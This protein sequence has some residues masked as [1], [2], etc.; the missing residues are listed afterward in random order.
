MMN[1]EEKILN[2]IIN[3]ARRYKEVQKVVLFGSR[4]RGNHHA[5]SDIDLAVY[6][7]SNKEFKN[8][9]KLI[10]DI[11]G[12]DT[13]YKFDVILVD[14]YLEEKL[15]QNID[16][17]GILIMQ[18]ETKISNFL[19]A[20]QRL[21]EALI[22]CGEMPTGLNRDGVIQ[23]FE[24]TT[25]L[26]WKACREHL[27]DLGFQD[28]NGPKPVMK[29]AFAYGLVSDSEGWIHIINDRNLTSHIYKENT[30]KEIYER[31]KEKHLKLF[32]ELAKF[33]VK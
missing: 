19:N 26:A 4:A 2:Q 31:I 21:N 13:L 15:N 29:E 22:E 32:N 18:N 25:E 27:M 3:I 9:Y 1:I 28:I 6:T 16:R 8:F 23:R 30:A 10:G 17:E 33:F 5:N 11:E 24:F 7:E 20:V 14:Q 12:I